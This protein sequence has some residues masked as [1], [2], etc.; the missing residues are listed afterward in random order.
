MLSGGL[1][2]GCHG[3]SLV[4][5]VNEGFEGSVIDGLSTLYQTNSQRMANDVIVMREKMKKNSRGRQG[6]GARGGK[7]L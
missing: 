6:V 2:R 5:G 3:A 7:E 1:R 4:H